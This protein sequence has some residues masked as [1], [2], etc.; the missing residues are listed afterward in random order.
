MNVKLIQIDG[1]LPNL[2]LMRLAAYYKEHNHNVVF[3]RS[4]NRDLFDPEFDLIFASS[5][6]KFSLNRI[7]RLKQNYPK[8]VIGGTGTDNW[9]LKVE[10]Y[11][12]DYHKLDYE[13]YPDYKFSLGFTQRDVV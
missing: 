12:G 8:A 9:Q 1:K 10:D 4:V 3:T 5:I 11:I 13:F 7:E 2:A 6:F